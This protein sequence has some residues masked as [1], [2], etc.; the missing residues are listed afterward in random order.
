VDPNHRLRTT[1]LWALDNAD[2]DIEKA[3]KLLEDWY[4]NSMQRVTGWYKRETQAWLF[5]IGL[6]VAAIFN[7]D[8]MN[9]VEKLYYDDEFRTA[10]VEDAKRVTGDLAAQKKFG[11][12][13][14]GVESESKGEEGAKEAE[15][16]S[17]PTPSPPVNDKKP[18]TTNEGKVKSSN[19]N[20]GAAP[21]PQQELA[22]KKKE[23]QASEPA[24]PANPSTG[25]SPPAPRS[26][27]IANYEGASASVK[28][29]KSE[30]ETIGYPISWTEK[31]WEDFGTMLRQNDLAKIGRLLAGWFLTAIAMTL[32]APFWF[33]LLN[34]LV[35]LRSSLK[36]ETAARGKDSETPARGGAAGTGD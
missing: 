12:I 18:A 25:P 19:V 35:S 28:Q 29:L 31:S 3:R 23:Q 27:P 1:I 6:G 15:A 34:K 11:L 13:T 8:T 4:D 9:V 33:D 10:A 32:G 20:Q 24:P 7:M 36:P 17:S 16:T 22:R 21:V 26:G 5:F 14:S 2:E 30:L